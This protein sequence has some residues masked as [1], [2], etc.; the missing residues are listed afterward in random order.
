[1]KCI[2][3]DK[4]T[5]AGCAGRKILEVEMSQRAANRVPSSDQR[6]SRNFR[7]CAASSPLRQTCRASAINRELSG[8][9]RSRA[10]AANAS[11]MFIIKEVE[12]WANLSDVRLLVA[13]ATSQERRRVHP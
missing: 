13:S 5:V 10:D 7:N 9:L 12:L 6:S 8:E 1:M 11:G 3:I 4:E 2:R